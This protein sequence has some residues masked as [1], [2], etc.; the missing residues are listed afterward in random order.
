M[1]DR[2]AQHR[3]VRRWIAPALCALSAAISTHSANFSRDIAPILA[4]ECL[5]CHNA[6]KAKGGYRVQSFAAALEPGKSKKAAVAPGKPEESQLY[7]R[8]VTHDEDER[9]PQ[10]DDPLTSPQIQLIHEWIAEGATLD[11]GDPQAPLAALIPPAPH[12]AP[13]ALYARPAPLLAIAFTMDGQQ[14]AVGGYH[15]INFWSLAGRLEKRMTNAPRRIH[16]IGFSARDELVAIAGGKPGTMGEL[17]VYRGGQVLTNLVHRADEM[18]TVAFSPDGSLLA[19]GGADN[20]IHVFQT[21]D[22][23]PVATIQQHADWV[24]SIGFNHDG[25]K[26]VSA[27]RDR[28]TRIYDAESGELETTYVTHNVPVFTAAFAGKD[29]VASAGRDKALHLWDAKEGKKRNE[30]TGAEAEIY[31][32][33]ATDKFLFTA[34]ADKKVRQYGIEDRKLVRTFTGHKDAVFAL[35]YHAGSGKLAAGSYDGAVRI[36]NIEDGTLDASFVASPV[37]PAPIPPE[38]SATP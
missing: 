23:R 18:L 13:P 4:S 10:D 36:W 5:A 24:T 34:S 35:S 31:E 25:T 15:E 22:W 26:I 12:P 6:E 16:A 7:Q 2:L 9:M 19:G 20:S 1:M 21:E 28:T 32:L 8:L 17:T 27:S 38:S 33:I 3:S 30:I 37:Q 11:R 14:L 29:T